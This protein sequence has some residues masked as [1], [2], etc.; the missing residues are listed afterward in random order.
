MGES[1]G[2]RSTVCVNEIEIDDIT[3]VPKISNVP[4]VRRPDGI[5]WMANIK[6]L[7]DTERLR[8]RLW[9]RTEENGGRYY[10]E[11]ESNERWHRLSVLLL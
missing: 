7:T 8:S 11:E 3:A 10:E 2:L 6:K 9:N 1:A 5:G 4:A